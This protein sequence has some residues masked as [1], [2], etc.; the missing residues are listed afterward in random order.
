MSK[1]DDYAYQLME[2]LLEQRSALNTL[3]AKEQEMQAWRVRVADIN[4]EL[5]PVVYD[6]AG[7]D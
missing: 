3:E 5:L 2:K 4:L 6:W 1:K 7:G